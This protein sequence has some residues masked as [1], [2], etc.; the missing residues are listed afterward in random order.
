MY[1]MRGDKKVLK[2]DLAEGVFDVYLPQLM[3]LAIRDKIIDTRNSE[4]F[5]LKEEMRIFMN[6]S[7]IMFHYLSS[8]VL[9]LD[10]KNAKKILDCYDF[11]QSQGY[12][13]KANI[14][15]SCR[16]VSL[17]DDFWISVDNDT[18]SWDSINFK[19]NQLDLVV[20][21]IA[22]LG[23]SLMLNGLPFTPELTCHGCCAKAWVRENDT[24]FLYKRSSP[25]G[26]ESEIEIS[27]SKILDC[28][29]VNH[30]EYMPAEYL[31]E[32]DGLC[33]CANMTS[34]TL[35]IVSAMDVY[36]YVGWDSDRFLE[37]CLE[38]DSDSIYK[39]CIVDYLISNPD[40]HLQNWGFYEDNS[41]GEIL[42]CHP[43]FDHNKAFDAGILNDLDG[44]PSQI[45]EGLNQYQAAL[46]SIRKCEFKM[47]RKPHRN[48]FLNREMYN[49]FMQ[50]AVRLGLLRED[51]NPFR[52]ANM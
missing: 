3:P 12:R 14:A 27:V 24:T 49:S 37:Y 25:G 48:L 18:Y 32:K 19:H 16:G 21:Q 45:F 46:K 39:M 31:N 41:T 8:R 40:R 4:K 38:H 47:L 13:N 42:K 6:N 2:F 1:L 36:S 17:I 5:S 44:G 20:T 23:S 29:N 43:L 22:L 9:N 11:S 10:R 26:N 50:K 35:S 30:V 7:D 15:I 33:K 34:D 28:F 51:K 52:G